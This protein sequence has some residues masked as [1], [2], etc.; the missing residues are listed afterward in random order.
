MKKFIAALKR[1]AD[2]I[3]LFVDEIHMLIG[4]GNTEG[5]ADAAN[6]LKPAL[7][8]GEL[9]CI[10]AT[11]LDEYQKYIERD[12]ALDRRFQ[13]LM[14]RE[15]TP[16][17]VVTMLRGIKD[18]Y[19]KHHGVRI[20]DSALTAA[21]KL[22]DKYVATRRFPDKAID[23]VDEAASK[24]AIDAG[25]T[26]QEL[27]QIQ[28]EI[29]RLEV[30]REAI[31]AKLRDSAPM[32]ELDKRIAQLKSEWT[33]LFAIVTEYRALAAEV[34]KLERM[35]SDL[36]RD[37]E[38]ASRDG[39]FT[40][41]ARIQYGETPGLQN[42]LK[43]MRDKVAELEKTHAFLRR[44]VTDRD[45]ARVVAEWTGIPLDRF[46]MNDSIVGLASRVKAQVFG[47]DDAIDIV[48]RSLN[49]ARSG[50][51]GSNRP[52]GVFLFLGPT[53]VGKTETAKALAQELFHTRD[54]LVR[55]DMSEYQEGHN[56]ARLLGA[57]P[58]YLGHAEGGELIDRLRR[59]PHSIVLLD[60]IDK[61]APQILD[62]L[63]QAF[64]DGRMTDGRG[65]TA[66]LRHAVF[67]MTANYQIDSDGLGEPALREALLQFMRPEMVN[68]ID[69]VIEFPGLASDSLEQI[70]DKHVRE[71]NQSLAQHTCMVDLGEDLRHFVLRV[72]HE[73]GFGARA[74]RRA[75]E[76]L[77]LD[78]VSE[79]LAQTPHLLPGDWLLDMG[80]DGTVTWK[81][82]YRS[83]YYL[84]PGRTG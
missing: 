47:Q 43:T 26:P 33:K 28:S 32:Q 56:V 84:P 53:G 80:D 29:S 8:R 39:D 25:S 48:V 35:H 61:A 11:T 13:T 71:L 24:L 36:T 58:G 38:A 2:G 74:I 66:D 7:A 19:E 12:P 23:A 15:P 9:H 20:E 18:R 49:R 82:Q 30:D 34:E 75:V 67:I 68:R 5:G 10:G 46:G 73:S 57:P 55:F 54:R 22:T 78:A 65:R 4:A 17:L 37:F 52:Q 63:L 3:I 45:I 42:H 79:R 69:H 76:Q 31:G 64:D 60:E 51:L 27:D 44:S 14:V 62:V 70:L 50:L 83:D 77:I 81:R 21:V 6:L 16:D 72:V 40:R 41:A 1:N 59:D